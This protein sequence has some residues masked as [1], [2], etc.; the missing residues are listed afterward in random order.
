MLP[1]LLVLGR[2]EVALLEQVATQSVLIF[3]KPTWDTL[4]VLIVSGSAFFCPSGSRFMPLV[5]RVCP[6]Q[7]RVLCCAC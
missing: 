3:R 5:E 7:R 6:L 1:S 4:V 2:L